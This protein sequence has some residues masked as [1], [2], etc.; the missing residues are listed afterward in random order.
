MNILYG[1]FPRGDKYV[2]MVRHD[3]FGARFKDISKPKDTVEQ[4][5]KDIEEDKQKRIRYK[6]KEERES[7]PV[8]TESF[9]I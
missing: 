8:H 3:E 4:S 1:V 5:I 7:T 9:K 6:M 2:A